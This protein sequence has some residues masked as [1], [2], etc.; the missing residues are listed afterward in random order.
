MLASFS[1]DFSDSKYTSYRGANVAKKGNPSKQ[2]EREKKT[3]KTI[4]YLLP[5]KKTLTYVGGKD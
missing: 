1:V 2:R 3:P 4:I 5:Q